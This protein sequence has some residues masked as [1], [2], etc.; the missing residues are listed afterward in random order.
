MLSKELRKL[1]NDPENIYTFY[2]N[3][4]LSTKVDV[5]EINKKET[6]THKMIL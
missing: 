1:K 5:Q 3:L 4:L 6:K 2:K